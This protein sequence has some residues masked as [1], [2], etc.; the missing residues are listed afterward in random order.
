MLGLGRHQAPEAEAKQQKT[1]QLQ[2]TEAQQRVKKLPA[3]PRAPTEDGRNS[4]TDYDNTGITLDVEG[5][6]VTVHVHAIRWT[7]SLDR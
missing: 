4:G 5:G 2:S 6:V 3:A 7:S 1:E